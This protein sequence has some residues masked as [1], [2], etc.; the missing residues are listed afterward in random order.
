MVDAQFTELENLLEN[1]VF[2]WV[3]DIGQS[4]ISS[5]WVITQKPLPGNTY[6]TKAR[7]VA[8]GFEER[9]DKKVDSPTSSRES[10]RFA[11][12]QLLQCLGKFIH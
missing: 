3:D 12:L 1:D 5:R 6:K 4:A 10:P 9:L 11:L 7:L 8:R 2:E